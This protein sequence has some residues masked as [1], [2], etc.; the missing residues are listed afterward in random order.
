MCV[1]TR[2]QCRC[3]QCVVNVGVANV[4]VVNVG[5]A[6]H[7]D[8]GVTIIAGSPD[9]TNTLFLTMGKELWLSKDSYIPGEEEGR[10]VVIKKQGEEK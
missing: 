10:R 7:L 9:M 1:G 2:G 8:V 3:G 6:T 5:G 4:G